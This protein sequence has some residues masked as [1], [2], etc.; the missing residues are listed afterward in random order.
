[1]PGSE[2]VMRDCHRSGARSPLQML[3]LLRFDFVDGCLKHPLHGA[4]ISRQALC[5]R[6][7]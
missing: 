5:Q 2:P 1:M 7:S 3:V 4:L 6:L